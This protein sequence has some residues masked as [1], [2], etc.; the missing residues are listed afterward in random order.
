MISPESPRSLEYFVLRCCERLG[1]REEEFYGAEYA[2][3]VRWLAY[4]RVRRQEE[5]RVEG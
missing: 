5:L 2:Q 3:Q 4:E 1:V